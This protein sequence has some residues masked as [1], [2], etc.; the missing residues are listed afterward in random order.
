MD[1]AFILIGTHIEKYGTM[2]S[3]NNTIKIGFIKSF[4]MY[5]HESG[6]LT[7]IRKPCRN[8]LA[9]SVA[10]NPDKNGYLQFR[11]HGHNLLA[12]RVAWAIYYGEWPRN[13]IDHIN[14][15]KNDNRISNLRQANHSENGCNRGLQSNNTS[16]ISGVHWHKARQKWNA[17]IKINRNHIHLGLFDDIDEAKLVMEKARLDFHGEFAFVRSKSKQSEPILT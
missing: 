8:I 14:G 4:L 10:G 17:R 3:N 6:E 11:F 7:Y 16:G 15:I 5:C 13:Q 1:V 9:G 2:K 12:H